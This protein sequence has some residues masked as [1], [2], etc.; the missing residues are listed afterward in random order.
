MGL[1][2]EHLYGR[3]TAFPSARAA[4]TV[5]SGEETDGEDQQK[6]KKRSKGVFVLKYTNS[7]HPIVLHPKDMGPKEIRGAIRQI[8][9][10]Y[11][12]KRKLF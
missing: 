12:R 5:Q 4:L 2:A 3:L 7:G 1:Y 8:L 10:Y 11:Y 6:S 9:E